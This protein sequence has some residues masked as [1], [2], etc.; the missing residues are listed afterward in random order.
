MEHETD[1]NKWALLALGFIILSGC[2]EPLLTF[3]GM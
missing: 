3:W 1:G 2:V